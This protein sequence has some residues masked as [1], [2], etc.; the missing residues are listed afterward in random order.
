MNPSEC[1]EQ[2]RDSPSPVSPTLSPNMEQPL[3]SL[4][5]DPKA[6]NTHIPKPRGTGHPALALHTGKS[7]AQGWWQVQKEISGL[8]VLI[9][10]HWR[11]QIPQQLQE[12]AQTPQ[13]LTNLSSKHPKPHLPE[14]SPLAQEGPS[15]LSSLENQ[16]IL[17][18]PE[19]PRTRGETHP[20]AIKFL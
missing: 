20:S 11:N 13:N 14:T 10:A 3:L 7:R 12:P 15:N 16:H 2:H 4:F 17:N 8:L 18:Q 9:P 1:Q 6:P 19:Y 5:P